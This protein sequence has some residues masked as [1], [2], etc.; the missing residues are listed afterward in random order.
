MEALSNRTAGP[1]AIGRL[2]RL[3]NTLNT[4]SFCGLGQAVPL[5]FESALH[6]FPEVF[7]QA[8][9]ESHLPEVCQ[10]EA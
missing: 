3:L 10:E 4:T 8:L 6:N 2:G 5:A 7:D 9:A 1:D